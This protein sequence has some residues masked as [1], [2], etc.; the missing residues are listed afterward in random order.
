MSIHCSTMNLFCTHSNSGPRFT[1][2]NT[3]YIYINLRI[4]SSD[5]WGADAP[6]AMLM[7]WCGR[8][9]VRGYDVYTRTRLSVVWLN[10]RLTCTQY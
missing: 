5:G 10:E 9:R 7:L 1:S 6:V 8:Q 2:E 3:H 4:E